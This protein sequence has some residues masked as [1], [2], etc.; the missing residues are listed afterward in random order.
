MLSVRWA[1]IGFV[2]YFCL[3]ALAST[4]EFESLKL[5]DAA[6]QERFRRWFTFLAEVQYFNPADAR[7]PEIT[8]CS[9]LIRYAY[10]EALRRHDSAWAAEA[11]LPLIPAMD[12][13]RQYNYPHTPVGSNLFLTRTGQF[14]EFADA[15][16]LQRYNSFFI[17]RD[18]RLCRLGDLLFFRR[19]GEHVS[20]HSMIYVGQ[21]AIGSGPARYVV[22]HT[23]PHGTSPG[24]IRRLTIDELL[25]YPDPEWQP[26]V[27]NSVFLGVYRWNILKTTQ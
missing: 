21:S 10:R 22:Y 24:E 16:T 6:D 20:F 23:G 1:R 19:S 25:H 15:E 2:S 17:G 3:A 9:S 5:T 8:D 12:S 18:V 11:R 26:R 4:V 13:V 7:P 27:T 14:R